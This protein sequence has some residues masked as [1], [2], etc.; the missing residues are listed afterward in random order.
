MYE[1]GLQILFGHKN[2]SLPD[3]EPPTPV[4]QSQEGVSR[5]SQKKGEIILLLT[6]QSDGCDPKHSMEV[7]SRLVDER[8]CRVF[9]DE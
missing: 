3:V 4:A 6:V 2:L 9:G 5:Y 8:S 1:L 7:T